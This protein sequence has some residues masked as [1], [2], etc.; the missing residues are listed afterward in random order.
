MSIN[1]ANYGRPASFGLEIPKTI[2]EL[3]RLPRTRTPRTPPS[4]TLEDSDT[5]FD[6]G[7]SESFESFES[8][9]SSHAVHSPEAPEGRGGEPP[10]NTVPSAQRAFA[11]IIYYGLIVGVWTPLIHWSPVLYATVVATHCS[12]KIV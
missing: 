10:L 3:S 8:F 7:S 1:F 6:L 12:L 9:E 4:G 2:N 5:S 11:R